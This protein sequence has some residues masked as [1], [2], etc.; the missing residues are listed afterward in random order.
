MVVIG[1]VVV[2]WGSTSGSECWF[3]GG[4]PPGLGGIPPRDPKTVI[5]PTEFFL[6]GVPPRKL[7]LTKKSRKLVSSGYPPEKKSFGG[8]PPETGGVPPE[9]AFTAYGREKSYND[10]VTSLGPLGTYRD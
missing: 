9:P 2:V 8:Y 3:V 6:G 7:S 1:A 4:Y 10:V 5:F